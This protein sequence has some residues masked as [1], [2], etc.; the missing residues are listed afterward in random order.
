MLR[1]LLVSMLLLSAGAT[2]AQA[3]P[4]PSAAEVV[5]RV[6]EALGG[7]KGGARVL[8]TARELDFIYTRSVRDAVTTKQID[9]GHRYV[10]ADGGRRQ[11][12]DLRVAQDGV[13]SGSIIDG[14]TAWVVVGGARHDVDPLAIQARLPEFSP[15][16]MF[17]V[18][19]A[20]AAEGPRLLGEATLT[21]DERVDEGG[22]R[23]WVLLGLGEDGQETARLEVDAR[24]SLPL[25]VAFRSPAG[26]VVYRYADFRQVAPGLVLPFQ[27]EFHRNGI[28]ISRTEVTRL[29]LEVDEA[30]LFSPVGTALEALPMTP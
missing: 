1:C 14:K 8:G 24:T 3:A 27:R 15:E 5:E 2:A 25:E 18:P 28:R 19:L 17:S 10:R 7:P 16:R 30:P 12:L 11:R 9:A 22:R 6:A 21:V 26:H 4:K 29:R 20:L 23:R 13:D